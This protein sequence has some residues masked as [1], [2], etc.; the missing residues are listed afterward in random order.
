MFETSSGG[1]L[2][3]RTELDGIPMSGRIASLKAHTIVDERW[4]SLE[5]ALIITESY[6]EA[7]R[8]RPDEAKVLRR[9]RALDAS[10]RKIGIDIAQGELIVGNRTK[11]V[12][13]GVVFPEAG[14]EWLFREIDSLATRP[15]DPF[16]V[17]PEDKTRF[18]EE[19]YPYWKGKT[20]EDYIQVNVGAL[21]KEIG[22]VAKINQTDHAQGHIMPDVKSWLDKGPAGLR[23]A[24]LA[25]LEG[26]GDPTKRD[27]LVAVAL[28]LEGASAFILRYAELAEAILGGEAAESGAPAP[29]G[30]TGL[31]RRR[32]E[33]REIARICRALAVRPPKTFHEALQSAWFLFVIL[34]MESNA[35]SFSPGRMDQYLF[36]YFEAD[37]AAKRLTLAS[38]LELL[39]CL[40]LSFNKIVY[41]RNSEGAKYF[42]GFPIGFN[43]TIG[44]SDAA[45]RDMSNGLTYLFLKAQEHLLLPQPNLTARL[46]RASPEDFVDGCARVI[47]LGSGMPQVVNDESIV[48]A[49]QRVGVSHE[50][51]SNYGLVGCVELS[52]Q[53]N[54]LGW[55][56]AAM[57]NLSKALE[58]A[59]NGGLCLLSGKKMGLDL[60][61][62]GTYASYEELHAAYRAEVR[63]F[64]DRMIEACDFVDRA[65]AVML[66]SPFL[67][68][69][70][71]DCVG[72]GIDVTAG[73]A[74]YNLS[75]IQAI[76]VANIAD[77]LAA[78]KLLV[79][80]TKRVPAARLLEALRTDWEGEEKLRQIFIHH[81]PKYG[82]DIAWVDAIGSAE[83]S[84]FA[85]LLE[86]RV[87]ARGGPYHM[88]LYTVSAHVPMGKNVGAGPDGRKAGSPLAD[89]GVSPMYGRDQK[90]PTAVLKS[91]SALDFSKASN[92]TLLNMKF[93]PSFFTVDEDRRKFN[94]LLRGFVRSGIHHAQFNVVNREDL[95]DAQEHPE[96]HR[97]LTIRV[98]GYTAYFT[99]LAA[100]LQDEII[101]RTA[102]GLS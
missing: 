35:S 59:L 28:S 43:V 9:A 77:S 7:D 36:P 33:L 21:N 58:L 57:F 3:L 70:I 4:L 76:Q 13:D 11:G 78:L 93:V 81:A 15:Q 38:A 94:L 44:G 31:E 84:Y 56:D 25:R 14:N 67:S 71:R 62:L 20:L 40:Y 73:G 16:S 39:E 99:E 22:K 17:R 37:L 100:D 102:H 68:S 19:V 45:G 55:S 91:V 53:G 63:S 61:N 52:T 65:H 92:G 80:D 97:N 69:V 50:D 75:G 46:H 18:L 49:L 90:G 74:V 47:G 87:N 26:E 89:G 27:F 82:N 95:L 98:A 48:P 5:Q 30:A 12:R 88:G 72:K 2:G 10:L 83:A 60:G 41:M 64:V 79:Y 54:N 51:A 85:S 24:A 23:A 101:E 86:G 1:L 29:G 6:K 32:G 96:R 42:A 34:Q 8:L 66:P